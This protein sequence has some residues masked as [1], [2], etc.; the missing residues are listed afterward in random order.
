MLFSK[1]AILAGT[2]LEGITMIQS[3]IMA[4]DA[5]LFRAIIRIFE[6][7]T[8]DEQYGA[9][10]KH[11]NGIGFNGCDARFMTLVANELLKNPN[12][13][14]LRTYEIT[15]ARRRIVK[16]ASQLYDCIQ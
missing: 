15:S 7:Q 13:E 14:S 12:G 9:I 11:Q 1:D 8:R 2:R 3:N 6:N 10:T 4:S 16:Y 5:W